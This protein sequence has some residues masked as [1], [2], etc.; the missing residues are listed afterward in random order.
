MIIL[1]PV[2]SIT[3]IEFYKKVAGQ[4]WG[5]SLLYLSYL[6]LL[7]SIVFLVF[8]KMR[9]WP[10]VEGTFQWLET[11]VPAVTYSKGRLSTPTNEKV[12]VRHPT[13]NEVAFTI[14][15]S[16]EEPVTAQMLTAEKVTAYVTGNA[17]Y[18]LQPAGKVEVYDLSK[19]PSTQ[20]KVFDAKFYRELARDLRLVLYPFGFIAAFMLFAVWKLVATLFYSLIAL[21]INGLAESGLKYPALFNLS[22]YAQTLVI[23]VQCILLL[24]PAQVPQFTLLSAVATTVYLWLAIKK[25][26]S[27][28]PQAA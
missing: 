1:D 19:V 26:A 18:V 4:T 8:L 10:S 11:S 25:S 24:V 13:I 14:D 28:R 17:L 20:T 12:T 15:T 21:L 27:P 9:V 5:R 2:N 22:V 7:F 16:R 23:A 3:S 6:G